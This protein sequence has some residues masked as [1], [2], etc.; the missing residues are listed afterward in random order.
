MNSRHPLCS[1]PYSIVDICYNKGF[2][3]AKLDFHKI[4]IIWAVKTQTTLSYHLCFRYFSSWLLETGRV[5]WSGVTWRL[6]D[7]QLFSMECAIDLPQWQDTQLDELLSCTS[8][9]LVCKFNLQS[10]HPYSRPEV[11]NEQHNNSHKLV[12]VSLLLL[13]KQII[14]FFRIFWPSWELKLHGPDRPS[15]L[16]IA[17]PLLEEKRNG[18]RISPTEFY[19][20]EH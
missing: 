13:D 15:E 12:F 1:S 11:T 14:Q 9:V 4:K 5:Y 10:N 3:L 19:L 7:S 16:S 2:I 8:K 17:T 6:L 18:G 20:S